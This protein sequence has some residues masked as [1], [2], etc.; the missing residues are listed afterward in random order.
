MQIV[1]GI[2]SQHQTEILKDIHNAAFPHISP[3]AIFSSI[4][5]KWEDK[6]G[7]KIST[8]W[9]LIAIIKS[10]QLSSLWSWSYPQVHVKHSVF[11]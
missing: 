7:L 3:P 1:M 8:T 2:K 4:M 10:S 6:Q 11:S 5:Y 9:V